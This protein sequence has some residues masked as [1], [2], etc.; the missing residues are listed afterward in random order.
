MSDYS[1]HK[2]GII[3]KR[4]VRADHRRP[5]MHRRMM[6]CFKGGGG[7]DNLILYAPI[8]TRLVVVAQR[9]GI[10]VFCVIRPN[11]HYF[12]LSYNELC[13]LPLN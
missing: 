8:D 11:L 2:A 9:N 5:T 10:Y 13:K 7:G 1:Y 4:S 12:D 6:N 3:A